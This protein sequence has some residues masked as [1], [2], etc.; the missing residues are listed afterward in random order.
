MKIILEIDDNDP[1][2]RL[3]N[4]Y[5]E[6]LGTSLGVAILVAATT[7]AKRSQDAGAEC[8]LRAEIK[9]VGH[10]PGRN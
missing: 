7:E 10:P 6:D 9:Q 8:A 5:A 2:L 3:L 1:H 4:D